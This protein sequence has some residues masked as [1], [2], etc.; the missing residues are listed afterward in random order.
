VA[1]ARRN[2]VIAVNG[3]IPVRLSDY[4]VDQ[5]NAGPFGGIDNADIE[6]LIAFVPAP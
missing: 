4:D 2:G 3:T 6:L 5:P 1:A